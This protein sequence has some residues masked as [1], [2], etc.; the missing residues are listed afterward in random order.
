MIRFDVRTPVKRSLYTRVRVCICVHICACVHMCIVVMPHILWILV[1]PPGM[2]QALR[3][4][5]VEP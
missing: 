4:E 5:G 1:P 2:N 3:R